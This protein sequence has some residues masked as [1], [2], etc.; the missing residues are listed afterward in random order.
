MKES[1]RYDYGHSRRTWKHEGRMW[2]KQTPEEIKDL[3][4]KL[5]TK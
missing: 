3:Y 2:D 4:A 5:S 1:I